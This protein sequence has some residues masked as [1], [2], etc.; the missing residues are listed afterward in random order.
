MPLWWHVVTVGHTMG[1]TVVAWCV[2]GRVSVGPQASQNDAKIRGQSQIHLPA[3]HPVRSPLDFI[4]EI[5]KFLEVQMGS[6]MM[7]L[8]TFIPQQVYE[9]MHE[10]WQALCRNGDFELVS[11]PIVFV[12]S[13]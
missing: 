7:E 9:A 1:H 13:R 10:D 3:R 5:D 12:S 2:T 8:A 4:L 11:E 6:N